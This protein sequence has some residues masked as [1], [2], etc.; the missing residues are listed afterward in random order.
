MHHDCI[1]KSLSKEACLDL[2]LNLNENLS[3]KNRLRTGFS[4][5]SSKSRKVSLDKLSTEG[6]IGSK[7]GNRSLDRF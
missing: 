4:Y 5:L 1:E 2:G 6:K 7:T 3:S